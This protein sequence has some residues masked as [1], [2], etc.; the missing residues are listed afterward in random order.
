MTR[1]NATSS[2]VVLGICHV[3][4]LLDLVALPLWI[5]GLIQF[6]KLSPVQAG[7][8]VTSFLVSVVIAS[9]ILAPLYE[10]L[11]HRIVV[12][13]GF[14]VSALAFGYV[15]TV[16]V[17]EASF[18]FL[19]T[20]HAIA[21]LATGAALS[22]TH[23]TIGR[24]ENPH[25]LFGWL[26]ATVGIFAIIFFAVVPGLIQTVGAHVVFQVF[27]AAMTIGAIAAVIGFPSVVVAAK[28]IAETLPPIP[29]SAWLVIFAVIC[30]IFNQALIFAFVERVGAAKGFSPDQVGLV[31]L[32]LAF[33]NLVPGAVAAVTQRFFSPVMVGMIGPVVQAFLALMIVNATSLMMYA[34][35]TIPYPAVVLFTHTYLFGLLATL[36]RSG[37]IVAATPAMMMIGAATGPAVGGAIVQNFGFEGLGYAVAVVA[38]IAVVLMLVFRMRSPAQVAV[39]PTA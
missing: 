29:K 24:T 10:K 7:G 20:M 26:N 22:M 35:F 13:L 32:I 4:C 19:V 6:Y 21:G 8:T 11:P 14:I 25:S 15:A 37:R 36:D 34:V 23:G 39:A 12:T 31:L 1:L 2:K 9:A 28:K 16:P 30:L 18:Q 3:V 27:A 33:V 38:V 17:A 5:G